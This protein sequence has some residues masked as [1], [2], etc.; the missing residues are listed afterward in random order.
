MCCRRPHGLPQEFLA[1]FSPLH[2]FCRGVV[3]EVLSA[4]QIFID[5]I[6]RLDGLLRLAAGVP[7]PLGD[8]KLLGKLKDTSTKQA[9]TP[10]MNENRY[11]L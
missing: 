8:V 4:L 10:S 11:L 5:L 1:C 3:C 7:E 2:N 9:A 6:L